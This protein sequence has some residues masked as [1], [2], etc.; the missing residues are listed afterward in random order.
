MF[1]SNPL[2]ARISIGKLLGFAFGLAGF[3]ML[4]ILAE[5]TGQMLRWGFLLWYVILGAVVALAG[6]VDRYPVIDRRYPWW[7]RGAITGGWLNLALVLIAYPTLSD[8]SL[9]MF[10]ADS[11]LASPWWLVLEGAVFGLIVDGICTSTAGEG[12]KLLPAK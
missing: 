2:I 1:R 10:G 9:A 5:N 6:I 8:L 11:M 3:F 7:L 4:P 12:K